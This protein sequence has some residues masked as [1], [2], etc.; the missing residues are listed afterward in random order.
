MFGFQVC[1]LFLLNSPLTHERFKGQLAKLERLAAAKY[2]S[3][4]VETTVLE[5]VHQLLA[6]SEESDRAQL[7]VLYQYIRK[8]IFGDL[9]GYVAV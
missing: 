8:L 5:V 3:P 4:E 2:L 9:Y 6:A 1:G 7:P